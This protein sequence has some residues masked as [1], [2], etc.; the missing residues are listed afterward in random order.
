M[1]P[2]FKYLDN[3]ILWLVQWNYSGIEK[4]MPNRTLS[5]KVRPTNPK[6]T[7]SRTVLHGNPQLDKSARLLWKRYVDSLKLPAL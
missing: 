6:L 3:R 5:D 4:R 1:F 2:G 7:P